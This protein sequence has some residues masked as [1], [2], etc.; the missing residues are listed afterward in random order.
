[1]AKAEGEEKEQCAPAAGEQMGS[2]KAAA[3]TVQKEFNTGSSV[4][5]IV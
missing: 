5:M 2:R 1:M 3:E 4:R